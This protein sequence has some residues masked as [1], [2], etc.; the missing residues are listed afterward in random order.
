M[1]HR[2]VDIFTDANGM[3][4]F[5]TKGDANLVMDGYF[6]SQTN[7]VGKVIWYT[8]ENNVLSTVFSFFTNKVGFLACVVFPCLLM[9]SL[10][11]RDCVKNIRNEL[12]DAVEDMNRQQEPSELLLEMTPEEIQAMYDRIRAE[13][14]EELM[15]GADPDKKQ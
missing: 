7:F 1:T 11:L 12:E 2:V 4:L 8:G 15:Q 14:M 10:I 3:L 6:V 9:A 13:L 5:E